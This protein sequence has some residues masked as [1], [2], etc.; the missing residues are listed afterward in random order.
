MPSQQLVAN[1]LCQLVADEL[2]VLVD[3]H[4]LGDLRQVLAL[5]RGHWEVVGLGPAPG[6]L[7][8]RTEQWLDQTGAKDRGAAALADAANQRRPLLEAFAVVAEAGD[9]PDT[10]ALEPHK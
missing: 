1:C 5:V 2:L 8:G 7:A 10:A 9:V 6:D 3:G 4:V